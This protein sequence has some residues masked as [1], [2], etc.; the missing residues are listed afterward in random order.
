MTDV[1]SLTLWFLALQHQYL[2]ELWRENITSTQL[3]TVDGDKSRQ[4]AAQITT[5]QH[6]KYNFAPNRLIPFSFVTCSLLIHIWEPRG[7]SVKSAGRWWKLP[8]PSPVLL[9]AWEEKQKCSLQNNEYLP[10]CSLCV[11]YLCVFHRRLLLG[12][13]DQLT[14]D[15]S[16]V[17][18][19]EKS[20]W[21]QHACMCVFVWEG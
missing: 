19:G 2:T 17:P 18:V 6:L 1:K 10:A 3:C 21:D 12:A 8:A 4:T 5:Q 13:I 7:T 16:C 11:F 14:G 15:K 9:N 20:D